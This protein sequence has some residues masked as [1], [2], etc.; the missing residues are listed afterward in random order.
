MFDV[1]VLSKHIAERHEI[2][3]FGKK[4]TVKNCV[5]IL[6]RDII[7]LCVVLGSEDSEM[8]VFIDLREYQRGEKHV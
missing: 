5:R 3:L 4:Y 6:E 7:K 1:E 8:S 2:E